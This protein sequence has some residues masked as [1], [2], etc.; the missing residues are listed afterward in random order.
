MVKK[1]SD[2]YLE[3]RRAFMTQ[4]DAQ[5][6]GL[7]ARNLLCHVTGKTNE[8]IL[9]DREMYAREDTCMAM[10]QAVTRVLAGEPL[11]YVL[12]Q[13]DFYGMTLQ[14]TKD[15]LIPRDDTCA[16]TDLA[17]RQALFLDAGPRI[18]DLCT[19]SGC[20]GLAIA[21]RVKDARVT[22]ADISREAMAVA[23]KNI[24]LQKLTG[25]V[26]CV[27]ADAM[28]KPAAFLGKF[29]MI[30][31]NPPYITTREMEELPESVKDYEPHLALH[32]GQD[33]LDFYRAIAENYRQ[34][35]KPGGY[36]CFEFGMGQGDAVCEILQMNGYT[37][38][39]RSRD[40][41]ERERAV[42]ARYDRKD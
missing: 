30:V 39:E 36:L 20:I 28:A 41:N 17:I 10:S 19:G 26:S 9:T 22:C 13:W 21:S 34:A 2:L 11:A 38:L 18:L 25:R 35:L 32:G 29:D 3:A 4:E 33:G 16:V 14:V 5:T 40:Y 27:Q 23:K 24:A 7:L 6:A 37:I 1:L 42:I 15:V 31:S 12:G 8:Q